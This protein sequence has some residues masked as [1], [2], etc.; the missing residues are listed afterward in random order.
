[1]LQSDELTPL[2]ARSDLAQHDKV[3]CILALEPDETRSVGQLRDIGTHH[4]L[5]RIAKWNLSAILSRLNSKGFAVYTGSGWLILDSGLRYLAER[6]L[7]A[8]RRPSLANVAS[9][10]RK[11]ANIISSATTREFVLEAIDCFEYGLYRGASVLS[12]VG[13]MSV[14]HRHLLSNPALLASFNNEASQRFSKSSKWQRPVK[15]ED[16]FGQIGEA[17]QLLVM[18]KISM[19]GKNVRQELVKCLDLRNG[20]GHPNTLVVGENRTAAHLETLIQNVFRQYNA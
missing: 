20:C 3:L 1:M 2:L 17:D 16:D 14:L 11:E 13:A 5:R 7:V 12:W 6:E 10:L 19:I 18:E 4:G 15:S 9:D 8:V